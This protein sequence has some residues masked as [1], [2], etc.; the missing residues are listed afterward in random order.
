[1]SIVIAVAPIKFGSPGMSMRV[2][3]STLLKMLL[4]FAI[5]KVVAKR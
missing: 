2:F 5:V 1:M 4:G 3:I